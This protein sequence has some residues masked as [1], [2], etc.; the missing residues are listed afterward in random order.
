[1][2]LI[3][4]VA[5]SLAAISAHAAPD[6]SMWDVL[7]K[8]ALG[9]GATYIPK[10]THPRFKSLFQ[11]GEG[12]VAIQVL[13]TDRRGSVKNAVM[14]ATTDTCARGRYINYFDKTLVT[15]DFS[16]GDP[17]NFVEGS[18]TVAETEGTFLCGIVRMTTTA[19]KG[20]SL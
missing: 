12:F 8:S 10:T 20:N 7:S 3:A 19:V 13:T 6:T 4:A 11:S 18:G 15:V 17:I 14:A 16:S 1:M 2:K 9:N 5:L